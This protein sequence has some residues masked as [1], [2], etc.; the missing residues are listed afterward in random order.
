VLWGATKVQR[1]GGAISLVGSLI[2]AVWIGSPGL[3]L[4]GLYHAAYAT[5]VK[6]SYGRDYWFNTLMYRASSFVMLLLVA[7]LN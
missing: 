3:A 5:L 6:A 7:L 1:F 2:A 4:A